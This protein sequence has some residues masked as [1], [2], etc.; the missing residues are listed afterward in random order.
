MDVWFILG[1]IAEKFCQMEM[2]WCEKFWDSNLP[3]V[4][5]GIGGI[6]VAINTLKTLKDQTRATMLAAEAAKAS[7]DALIASE[8]AWV[9]AELSPIATHYADRLWRRDIGGVRQPLIPAEVLRAEH[10][11]HLLKLTNMGRTPAH[12]LSFRIGYSCLPEGVTELPENAIG[13]PVEEMR[14][15]RLLAA[16]DALE[17]SEPIVKVQDYFKDDLTAIYDFKRTAVFYGWVEYQHVFSESDVLKEPFVYSFS[18]TNLRLNRVA[19]PRT[20][21]ALVSD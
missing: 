1:L 13:D 16:G 18:P 3:L 6:L 15:D 21:Q 4:A 17:I 19:R 20:Q 9:V 11:W 5:V 2:A 12:I 10:L 7:S 14:F 8:R